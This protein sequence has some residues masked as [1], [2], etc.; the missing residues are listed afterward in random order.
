MNQVFEIGDRIEITHRNSSM[1]RKTSD[2]KYASR[3]LDFDEIRTA[4]IAAPIQDGHLVPLTVGDDYDLCFFTKAGLYQCVARVKKRYVEKHVSLVEVLF[5]TDFQ[6]YQRRKFYRLECMF[7]IKYRRISR[8]EIRLQGLLEADNFETV[9]EKNKCEED[10]KALPKNWKD[11][12][13]TNLSGGGLRFHANEEF[14][15]D[16]PLQLMLPLSLQS[17]VVPMKF[18]AQVIICDRSPNSAMSYDTRCEFVSIRDKER[19]MIVKYVFEEQRR[20]MSKDS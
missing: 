17:G 2:K 7:G 5:V 3:V 12:T 14:D 8:E 6:K 11:A 1:N 9:A 10:L 18:D 20:R 19:E 16:E 4:K 13:I 15:R